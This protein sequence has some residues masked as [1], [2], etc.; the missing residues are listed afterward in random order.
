M[1]QIQQKVQKY[2]NNKNLLDSDQIVIVGL[3][4]G[5]D[6]MALL[7]I[8]TALG[9]K[10]IAAHCNFHLRGEE[11]DRDEDFV[12]NYCKKNDIEYTSTSFDT[13]AYIEE[14]GI[15]LEMAARELRYNWFNEI[16]NRFNSNK[17]AVAHHSDDSVETVLINITRGCGI[18]G[19]TGIPAENRKIIRP[20]L[21]INRKEV[22]EY[23]N[24]NNISFVEDS[25]NK[26]DAYTRNKIRLNILPLLEEI[27]PSAKQSIQQMT[28]YL[29]DVEAIYLSHI[30]KIKPEVFDG[31]IIDIIKLT[32]Y[33]EARTLLFEILYPYGF[34]QYV[35]SQ[36]Y[37]S[38][39]GIS[40]KTFYSANYRLTK[41]RTRFILEEKSENIENN[42]Y[43][44][45]E[46]DKHIN[47]PLI[48][49]IENIVKSDHF[50]IIKDQNILYIDKSKISYPLHLRKWKQGDK[51]IPIGMKGRKK[52]SDYFSDNKFSIPQKEN[53][54]LLCNY[55][56]EIIWIVGERPDNRFKVSDKT[57]NIVK[58][59]LIRS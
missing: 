38:I 53:T 54:W 14:K 23:L 32:T 12:E 52:I 28:E 7:H 16:S 56:N 59:V 27:N 3:S 43:F 22:I 33:P 2:I 26:E 41:D 10:C 11:S 51:F 42:V 31:K 49:D 37:D 9:Y 55:N 47:T 13:Y 6:S 35:I 4:G 8:L 17:I 29:S 57:T 21:C 1:V 30:S 19:L 15:S 45:E 20:L 44:I 25:T 18:R 5:A 36:A 40:G 34:N 24:H 50:C 48:L 46:T 58:I 39:Q